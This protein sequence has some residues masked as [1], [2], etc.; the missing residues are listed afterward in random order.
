MLENIYSK[1]E[2][3]TGGYGEK[4]EQGLEY[5]KSQPYLRYVVK[6]N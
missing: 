3:A 4:R 1:L 2:R 6:D 5:I